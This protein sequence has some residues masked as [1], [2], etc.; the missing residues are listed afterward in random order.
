M[1]PPYYSLIRKVFQFL[2]IKLI[3]SEPLYGQQWKLVWSDEFDYN[4]LPREYQWDFQG[5]KDTSIFFHY[6]RRNKQNARVGNGSLHISAHKNQQHNLTTVRLATEEDFGMKGGRLEM[7]VKI[8]ESPITDPIILMETLNS[9]KSATI[10]IT[11]SPSDHSALNFSI[12][13]T[14]G[15]SYKKRVKI[16]NLNIGYH[17]L[18]IEWDEVF[19]NLWIDDQKKAVYRNQDNKWPFASPMN[20]MVGLTIR[21]KP[22]GQYFKDQ[23]IL[24]YV[25]YFKRHIDPGE[26]SE[27]KF[28]SIENP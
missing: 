20:L 28:F 18:A 27:F 12:K 23:M 25:R 8:A 4:G 1:I 24:D 11:G 15:I 21:D 3:A 2:C 6:T 14:T 9:G 26:P 13:S 7:K 17:I 10:T 16:K 5:K 19:I 22:D